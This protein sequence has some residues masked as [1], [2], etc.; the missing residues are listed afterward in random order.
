[1]SVVKDFN[2]VLDDVN[3]IIDPDKNE[4]MKALNAM[5]DLICNTL[6]QIFS[7]F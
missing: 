6:T 4:I 3:D 1:M 5:S 2:K 7:M